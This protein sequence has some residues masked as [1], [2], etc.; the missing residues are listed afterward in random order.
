MGIV[1]PELFCKDQGTVLPG[2]PMEKNRHLPESDAPGSARLCRLVRCRTGDLSE[3]NRDLD[4]GW[5]F[6]PLQ[7]TRE[8]IFKAP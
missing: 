1:G 2:L 7:S 3:Q 5:P 8:Q 4:E 6:L